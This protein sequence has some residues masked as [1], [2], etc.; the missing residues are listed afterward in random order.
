MGLIIIK[1]NFVLEAPV[2]IFD[3]IDGRNNI[4]NTWANLIYLSIK[5][6][7]L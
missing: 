4:E 3:T 1:L 2:H 6:E 5:N 7:I